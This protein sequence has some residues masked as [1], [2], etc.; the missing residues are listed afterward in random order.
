MGEL[1]GKFENARSEEH[2]LDAFDKAMAKWPDREDRS[3]ETSFG[4]TT[5]STV[6]SSG[7][8]DPL[9]L[10]QGGGSTVAVWDRFAEAWQLDRPIIA[11]DTVWDAGRS[12]QRPPVGDGRDAATW[13][14]ET[15]A[16]LDIDRAHLV[17]YSYGGWVALNHAVE[18]PERLLSVTAIEPPGAIVRMPVR[19]W[20]KMLRMLLGD[21]EQYRA[22]LTWVRGGR[23]PEST[24]LDLLMAART[25]F[26]QRGTPRPTRL[27]NDQWIGIR[28]P[29]TIMLGGR[30]RLVPSMRA[31]KVVR[32]VSP[33]AELHIL[34]DASHAVLVDEPQAVI[35]RVREFVARHDR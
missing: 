1:V 15:L 26:V 16:G 22:Y 3:V 4:S 14:E 7:T 20:W 13:L 2:F 23:L 28:T 24:M 30:S 17:G 9:V 5:V 33:H 12:V 27:T 29:L 31:S 21:D 10:L 18:A 11:V 6:C 8:G 25:D 32:G 19:A 35:D 34:P